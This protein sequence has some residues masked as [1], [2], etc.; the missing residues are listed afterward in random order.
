MPTNLISGQANDNTIYII[1]SNKTNLKSSINLV[2]H[3]SGLPMLVFTPVFKKLF[4]VTTYFTCIYIDIIYNKRLCLQAT[5]V[6]L[7]FFK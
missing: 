3:V 2:T 6:F 4:N 5:N 1:K 7:L